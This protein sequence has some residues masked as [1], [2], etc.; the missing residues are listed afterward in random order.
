M[1]HQLLL[2][3]V[4]T[5]YTSMGDCRIFARGV[6]TYSSNIFSVTCG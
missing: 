6:Q 5:V 4:K 3:L 2:Q 1:H